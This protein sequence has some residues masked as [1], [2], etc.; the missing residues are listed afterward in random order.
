MNKPDQNMSPAG[1]ARRVFLEN[2]KK[3]ALIA[4][5]VALLAQASTVMAQTVYAPSGAGPGAG[6][7]GNNGGGNGLDPQPPGNPKPNDT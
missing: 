4:P 3:A 7:K 6:P 1:Q 2:A 5:A